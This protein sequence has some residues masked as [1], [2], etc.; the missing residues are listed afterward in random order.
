MSSFSLQNIAKISP[1]IAQNVCTFSS[2]NC[3]LVFMFYSDYVLFCFFFL[4]VFRFAHGWRCFGGWI[5][6]RRK[7][8]RK[9]STKNPSTLTSHLSLHFPTLCHQVRFFI[10]RAVF[11]LHSFKSW[12]TKRATNFPFRA[13]FSLRSQRSLRAV[14]KNKRNAVCCCIANKLQHYWHW[15]MPARGAYTL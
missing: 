9:I 12:R 7:K 2:K 5:I 4:I 11:F 10:E 1:K 3:L 13:C 14:A 6:C 15:A 8:L